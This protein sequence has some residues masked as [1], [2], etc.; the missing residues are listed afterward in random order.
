MHVFAFD[1]FKNAFIHERA[2]NIAFDIILLAACLWDQSKQQ[3]LGVYVL[4]F[5]KILYW[6]RHM[7]DWSGL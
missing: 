1:A 2:C 5:H 3:L 4:A 6:E 7:D